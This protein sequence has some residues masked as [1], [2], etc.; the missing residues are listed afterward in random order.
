MQINQKTYLCDT[1]EKLKIGVYSENW[2]LCDKITEPQRKKILALYFNNK[3][4][5][6][7]EML[8]NIKNLQ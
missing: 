1:L 4:E 7:K 8:E 2:E 3:P 6:I 5:E